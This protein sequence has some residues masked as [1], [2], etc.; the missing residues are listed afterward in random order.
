MLKSKNALVLLFLIFSFQLLQTIQVEIKLSSSMED[1]SQDTYEISNNI[2][3]LT[4][5]EDYT[6]EGNCSECGIE[7]EEGISPTISLSSITI[8]NS[9]RGPFI[10]KNNCDVKLVLIGESTITDK[11]TNK[12]SSDFE[13]AGIKFKSG[14]NLTIS[15]A[16]SLIIVG[17]IKNGIKGDSLSNLIINGGTYNITS[18][19][20]AISVDD[21][22]IINDGYFYIKTKKGDGIKS[23]PD[24][25]DTDSQGLITING[26]NF[27]INSYNDGII[28][29]RKLTI[30]DGDF[31]IKTNKKGSL[32]SGVNKNKQS[33]KGIKVSTNDTNINIELVING[34]IFNLNTKDN[35]IHSDG[36]LTITGGNFIIKTGQDGIHADND[37][38]LGNENDKDDLININITKSYKGIEGAQV[39]IYSGTYRIIAQNDGIN[40]SG[41]TTE[42]CRKSLKPKNFGPGGN[43]KKPGKINNLREKVRKLETQCSIYHINI[44]GGNIYVNAEHDGLDANGNINIEGGNIE[45]WGARANSV[46]GFIGIDGNM[47]ITG[48]TIFA[49]GNSGRIN[50]SDFQNSQGNIYQQGKIGANSDIDVMS[51]NAIIQTYISPK[52]VN[53]IYYSSPS[54]DSNYKFNV[55]K[56]GSNNTNHRTPRNETS[57][58]MPKNK[59]PR[60]SGNIP[61]P[62]NF[63]NRPERPFNSS[64]M[65][66][67]HDFNNRPERSFNSIN[68]TKP[69]ER[70]F[71]SSKK[72]KSHNFNKKPRKPSNSSNMTSPSD[73]NKRP[74]RPSNS[75]NM[76][77]Q[78]DFNKRP[79]RPFNS[80][81]MSKPP[82]RPFNSSN[83][84]KPPDF[85]NRPE[86]PFN[87]SNMTKPPERPFNSSDKTKPHDF[88]NKREKPSN[89][90]NKPSPPDFNNNPER[91]SNS[92]N[93]PSP[94]NSYTNPRTPPDS[95]SNPRTPPDS[96][97]NPGTPPDSNSNPGTPPDSNSNPGTPP[98]SNSNPGTPPG[99]NSNPGTTQDSNSNP[100][101]PPNSNT[102]PGSSSTAA[103]VDS[104]KTPANNNNP[105]N[106]GA[107]T[108]PDNNEDED[109]IDDEK[110]K[111]YTSDVKNMKINLIYL[112]IILTLIL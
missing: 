86:R 108:V 81:N 35:A 77:S 79:E 25:N 59:K 27:S 30:N 75:S 28:A 106:A 92:S 26:G 84:P 98:D 8:D 68:M 80:S 60:N 21:S 61:K 103:S 40:S 11:E 9:N 102:D 91:P 73:F 110:I 53:Y 3:I 57:G 66:K 67:P 18:V 97:S 14:S 74:K 24:S 87:S 69:P 100:G 17:N 39:Y 51:G 85:N 42:E 41:E 38:I 107:N 54:V 93:M 52:K 49:G 2:V 4:K 31:N 12:T 13:G 111:A 15:G 7:V 65:T 1:S 64:N 89:S 76:T 56:T 94:P 99:S 83:M 71:N 29:K 34:G 104:N 33:P 10:I 109:D 63:N 48:G 58:N 32:K 16:G 101:T 45:I 95:N 112:M 20:N 90:N 82:E 37:L 72:T 43:N 55:S 70:P 105:N 50:S 96:N 6:I 47:S 19:K 22:I 36:N 78:P 5:N 44:Y 62:P 23:I 46:G 88:N